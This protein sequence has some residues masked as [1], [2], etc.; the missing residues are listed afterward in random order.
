MNNFKRILAAAMALTLIL[1]ASCSKTE[2]GA[3]TAA[4]NTET[5]ET[6]AQVT[7]NNVKGTEPET[8]IITDKD[9]KTKPN[10]SIKPTQPK[11]ET[12]PQANTTAKPAVTEAELISIPDISNGISL[13]S[14]TSPTAKGTQASVTVMGTPNKEFTIEF[15]ESGNDNLSK[16]A[17]FKAK[18][19]NSSGI[20]TWVFTVPIT[21]GS[22]NNKIVIKEKGSKNSLQTSITVK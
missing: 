16:S 14:K 20:V 17:D 13:L 9:G 1:L 2:D 18:T 19:S 12:K 3:V 22:G 10:D 5:A 21:C 6:K 15:Y 7:D 11:A 4:E 8:E